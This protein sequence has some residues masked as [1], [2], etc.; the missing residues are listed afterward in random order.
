MPDGVRVIVSDNTDKP[1]H[2]VLPQMPTDKLSDE[3]LD[4]L[5]GGKSPNMG[6]YFLE[7]S[8]RFIIKNTRT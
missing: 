3:V 8:P 2:L 6:N 5:A 1:L 7:V 4:Q